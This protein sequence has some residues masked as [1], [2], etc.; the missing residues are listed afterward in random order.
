MQRLGAAGCVVV[1]EPGYYSRF[2]FARRS[3][4][5]YSGVAPECFQAL[6]FGPLFVQG[7]VTYHDAFG[8]QG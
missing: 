1:G 4:L 2:G 6:A 7:M 3:E 8:A 5:T